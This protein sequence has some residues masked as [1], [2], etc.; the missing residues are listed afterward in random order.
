MTGN[1]FFTLKLVKSA[2]MGEGTRATRGI[3]HPILFS[4]VTETVSEEYQD[5]EM[6]DECV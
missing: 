3:F 4:T 6:K 2:H 1:F 5:L